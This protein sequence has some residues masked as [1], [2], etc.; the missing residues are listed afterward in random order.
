V[1]QVKLESRS[2]TALVTFD[3][4]PLNAFDLGFMDELHAAL[5]QLAREP[6]SA[7]L[8]LSGAGPAF[9]AG[10]DFKLVPRYGPQDARAM[11]ERVNSCVTL[12]YG[13]PTCTVAAVNGHAIG[14]GL[15]M[16]LACDAR[17]AAD[18]SMRLALTEITAG[19]PYPA[20]PMEVL[21]GE[22]EPSGRRRLVLSGEAVS[23]AQALEL[24]LVDELVPPGELLDRAVELAR[25][26]A[27]AASYA[28]V[29]QQLKGEA[30]AR[31]TA[32]VRERNDPLLTQRA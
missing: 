17:L 18:A 8:V 2:G 11:L 9:S 12:L 19:I 3:R 14:G 13:L 21:R 7:G 25:S 28:L 4:P 20:C 29:K 24:G 10:V 30:L 32:I 15:I 23:A 27:G 1:S 6:P 26:Q 16:A 22:L 31:M 5:Q